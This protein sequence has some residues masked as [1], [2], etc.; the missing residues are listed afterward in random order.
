MTTAFET[1]PD[2]KIA[3]WCA[4]CWPEQADGSLTE[5][6]RVASAGALPA[7]IRR[8]LG[9]FER[10]I[11]RCV[12]GLV[13][14]DERS[15]VTLG[16]RFGNLGSAAMILE[17]LA[18]YSPPSPTLFS[19]SV[20]NAGC[21]VA[22]QIRKDRSSHT[23]VSAGPRTLHGAM[24]EAWLQTADQVCGMVDILVLIDAPLPVSYVALEADWQFGTC[25]GMRVERAPSGS[26]SGP[27]SGL[28]ERG[29]GSLL[30]ALRAGKRDLALTGRDWTIA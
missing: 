18:A 21:G 24:T 14:A 16:S 17:S 1:A 12:L 10:S 30:T 7:G 26:P 22:N 20:L 6:G 8:R 4:V 27:A 15:R 3:D 28:G 11:V 2:L 13:A 9:E 23:A 5:E 29:F 25:I 19:H